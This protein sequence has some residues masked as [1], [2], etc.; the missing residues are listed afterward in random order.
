MM[1]IRNSLLS[2]LLVVVGSAALYGATPPADSMSTFYFPDGKTKK[3]ILERMVSDTLVIRIHGTNG[4]SEIRLHK[5]ACAKVVLP[6]HVQLDLSESS[7]PAPAVNDWTDIVPAPSA[8]PSGGLS[9]STGDVTATV[10][11]DKAVAGTTPFKRDSIF[12][13]THAL[14]ISA[15]GYA[16]VDE[17]VLIPSQKVLTREIVLE[18]SQAWKDSVKTSGEAAL[19]ARAKAHSDSV[20]AASETR[21]ASALKS[22]NNIDNLEKMMTA[23]FSGIFLD[24]ASTVAVLPFAVAAGVEPKVGTMAAEY[25]VVNLSS[26]KGIKV[27]ERAGFEKMMQELALSQSDLVFESKALAAGKIL[28]ARYLVMGNV[29]EDLGKRLVTIRIVETETGMVISAAAA[30]IRIRDMD[31]FT[32]DALGE[33]VDPSAAF[34]RS[35][36]LPGW[37]Q[38]YT[39]HPGQGV[40]ALACV[41]GGA[42]AFVWSVLDWT[43]KTADV[44]RYRENP[45]SVVGP[46]Q[47]TAE[48]LAAAGNAKISAQNKAA[49]RDVII[50]AALG[51]VWIVNMVD[52]L[53]CGAVESKHVRVRYFSV[54]P[55]FD[56]RAVGCTLTVNIDR[57]MRSN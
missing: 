12:A 18:H 14:S 31:A 24:T 1:P 16:T 41:L 3:G 48:E 49:T 51:G 7:W 34:F 4:T 15:A 30:S 56:G 19:A 47:S 8:V 55:T 36:V 32:H 57:S 35:T 21:V 28:A 33:K 23:L 25:A 50:G 9:V 11:I 29:T 52:A 38:F 53:L 54:A 20:R 2:A 10:S 22:S 42:G 40:A 5:S 13:G 26:R 39:G 46:G 6:S 44:N 45:A 17:S 27:V 43:D 37:G